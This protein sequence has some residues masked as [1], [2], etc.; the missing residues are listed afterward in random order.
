MVDDLFEEFLIIEKKE[1]LKENIN[2]DY[3]DHYW[4]L[5]FTLRKDQI[6]NFLLVQVGSNSTNSMMNGLN[7]QP[8]QH[9]QQRLVE[10]VL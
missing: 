1:I 7:N 9:Q 10:M 3:N 6:P 4:D 2:K 5:R 8:Q